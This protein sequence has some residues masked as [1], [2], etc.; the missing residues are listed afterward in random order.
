M[1]YCEIQRCYSLSS[2]VGSHGSYSH[3]I[4]ISHGFV[5]KMRF[6]RDDKDVDHL[7]RNHGKTNHV[8]CMM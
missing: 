1:R 7:V 8:G 2:Q 4:T 3:G 5:K 6:F